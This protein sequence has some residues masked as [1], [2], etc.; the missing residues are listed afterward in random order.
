MTKAIVVIVYI[1]GAP[2]DVHVFDHTQCMVYWKQWLDRLDEFQK[3][4]AH[5]LNEVIDN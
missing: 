5:D 4:F 2:A 1:S 3:M